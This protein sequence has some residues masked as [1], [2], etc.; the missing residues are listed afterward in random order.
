MQLGEQIRIPTPEDLLLD[1][2]I[3]DAGMACCGH[4]DR[5]GTSGRH[6]A[7]GKKLGKKLCN[8]GDVATCAEILQN[9]RRRS[10]VPALGTWCGDL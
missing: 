9:A 5:R 10:C 4:D 7:Q 6:H 8:S 2:M 3:I 1:T